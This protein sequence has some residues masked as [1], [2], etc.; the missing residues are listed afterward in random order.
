MSSDAILNRGTLHNLNA[1]RRAQTNIYYVSNIV[2][3]LL[4][5][6]YSSVKHNHVSDTS[7]Q[8]T[9]IGFSIVPL[10]E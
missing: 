9:E 6:S 7:M 4:P 2:F 1:W 5:K 10:P 3:A 8:L